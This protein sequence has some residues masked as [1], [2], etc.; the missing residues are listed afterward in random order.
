M[1]CLQMLL[2]TSRYNFTFFPVAENSQVLV[3]CGDFGLDGIERHLSA[4]V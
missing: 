2:H 1:L 4:S 3:S